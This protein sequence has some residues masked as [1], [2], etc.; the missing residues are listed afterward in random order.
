MEIEVLGFQAAKQVSLLGRDAF[1][2]VQQKDL[3][4]RQS[5]TLNEDDL[6][7]QFGFTGP[8]FESK[9]VLLLGI[10]PGN[11]PRND[12]RTSEDERMMPALRNFSR[13]PTEE[14]YTDASCAYMAECQRWPLWKRHC[15]EVIGA[16]KLE[17][18]QIAYS[19]C[20]P[21]RTASK[22][23][24]EDFVARKAAELYVRPLIDELKPSV[25]IAMGKRASYILNMTGF[26]PSKIVTWNRAQAARAAVL[27]DRALAATRVFA[28]VA[29]L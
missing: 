4:I 18:D 22:S 21:W 11:G 23:D 3:P 14:N 9:R 29:A 12:V 28:M 1:F 15:A 5:S 26:S 27:R 10:N 7:P 25:I 17:F 16:G 13:N 19:N 2:P 20:L 6:T 24:F 8:R